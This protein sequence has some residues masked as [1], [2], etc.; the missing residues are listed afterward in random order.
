[1]QRYIR[2]TCSQGAFRLSS[3]IRIVKFSWSGVITIKENYQSNYGLALSDLL[4][5]T[6]VFTVVIFAMTTFFIIIHSYF[7][8]ALTATATNGMLQKLSASLGGG[9]DS[10]GSK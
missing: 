10:D 9:A 1:M 2:I 6:A 5:E 4:V 7:R 8:V 3:P